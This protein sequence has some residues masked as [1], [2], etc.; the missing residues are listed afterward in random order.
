MGLLD[1]AIREHLELKRRTG[2]EPGEIAR[3]EQEALD[4][5]TGEEHW[6]PHEEADAQRDP[7]GGLPTATRPDDVASAD[8]SFIGD[9]HSGLLDADDSSHPSTVGQETAEL[10][11]RTVLDE[12]PDVASGE[13]SARRSAEQESS[14]WEMPTGPTGAA[15]ENEQKERLASAEDEQQERLAFE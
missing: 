11:M 15:A 13:V 14:E 9:Q 7:S 1:D 2:G 12:D 3:A 10:D 4:P 6:A 5:A 8:S